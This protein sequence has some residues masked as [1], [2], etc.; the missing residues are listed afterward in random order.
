MV[1]QKTK[2][3]NRFHETFERIVDDDIFSTVRTKRSFQYQK[4]I[5]VSKYLVESSFFFSLRLWFLLSFGYGL[6]WKASETFDLKSST[7]SR[8]P[9]KQIPCN[10]LKDWR[11]QTFFHKPDTYSRRPHEQIPCDFWKD[12]RRW[13]FFHSEDKKKLPVQE[14]DRFE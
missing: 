6:V 8:R 5:N 10:F 11:R 12:C 13:P 9:H 4:K 1:R 3:M 2:Q 7:Y 14:E